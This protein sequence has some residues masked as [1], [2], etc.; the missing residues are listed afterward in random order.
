MRSQMHRVPLY[1]RLLNPFIRILS[2]LFL[3]LG[4]A[5]CPDR[6][7]HLSAPGGISLP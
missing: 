1:P 2:C 4:A 5:S 6:I 7:T 3:H